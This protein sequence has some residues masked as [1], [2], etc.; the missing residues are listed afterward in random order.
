MSSNT[1]KIWKLLYS[2]ATCV[3]GLLILVLS[4][5]LFATMAKDGRE[6]GL[7]ID[8]WKLDPINDVIF[9][10]TGCANNYEEFMSFKWPGTV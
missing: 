6:Y 7:L 9:S 1:M 2:F 10:T 8:N 3:T 4:V 5:V